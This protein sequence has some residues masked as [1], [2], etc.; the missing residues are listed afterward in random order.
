MEKIWVILCVSVLVILL[1]STASASRNSSWQLER[2][3]S[4]QE[5]HINQES[6]GAVFIYDRLY[7]TDIETALDQQF[8]RID[9]MMFIRTRIVKDGE[10]T[11]TDDCD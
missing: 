1:I 2:L 7:E 11:E 5:H 10:V 9:S 4:P 8:N 6:K 3:L